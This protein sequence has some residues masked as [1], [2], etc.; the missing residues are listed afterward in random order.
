MHIHSC[1]SPCGDNDMTVNNIVN[2]AVIKGLEIIALTDHNSAKNCPPFLECAKNAGI[3][4]IPGMEINTMEEVHA[5]CLFKNLSDCMAFDEFVYNSLA[6]IKNKAEIFG[7]QRLLDS[8][9][10][11][12]GH[13]DKLLINATNISFYDLNALM[14]QYNGIYFPAHIDRDS[15][16]LISNLGFVPED[17]TM[18]AIEIKDM[19]NHAKI[20]ENNPIIQ[21][22]PIINNSDAHYLWDISEAVNK[23]DKRIEEL[24]L[25]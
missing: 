19:A 9:D 13:L 10:N 1:L 22:L 3:K 21:R 20:L 15:F 6:D 18:D 25:S 24:L 14:K 7:E 4:A 11:I 16:S 23:L 2:M 8:A 5:V 17:C 12:T